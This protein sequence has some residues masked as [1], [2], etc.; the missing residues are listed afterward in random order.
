MLPLFPGTNEEWPPRTYSFTVNGTTR[1]LLHYL[2]D[3]IFPRFEFIMSPFSNA[4]TEVE[5]TF[6]RIQEA[7]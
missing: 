2:A 6:N 5:L 7:D 3:G 4:T 1:T